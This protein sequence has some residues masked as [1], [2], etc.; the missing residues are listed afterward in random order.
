M[1]KPP[2]AILAQAAKMPKNSYALFV[3]RNGQVQNAE[4]C[5][6]DLDSYY[7]EMWKFKRALLPS[8]FK[9]ANWTAWVKLKQDYQTYNLN[10]PTV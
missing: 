8:D 2:D 4:F 3:V 7:E 6:W 5:V 10:S 9:G 1:P